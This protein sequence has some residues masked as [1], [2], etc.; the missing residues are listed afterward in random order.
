[1]KWVVCMKHKQ[2]YIIAE[3]GVNHNG[4]LEIAKQL[5][6]CAAEAGVDAIKFQT[7][8]AEALV[9][10]RAPKA[11]YQLQMTEQNESQYDMLKKLELNQL[12]HEILA[13]HCNQKCIDFLSTPFDIESLDLLVNNFNLPVIKVPSGEITNTPF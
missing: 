6:D 2:I 11:D 13:E 10:V 12:E 3:A 4:S 8:K 7:F 9:S 5:I 1:M